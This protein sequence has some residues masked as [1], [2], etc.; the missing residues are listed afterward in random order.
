MKPMYDRVVVKEI[1]PET[2][3]IEVVEER[4]EQPILGEVIAISEEGSDV[5]IGDRILF[6]K[7]VGTHFKYNGQNLICLRE[8]DIMIRGV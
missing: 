6:S 7:Y 2:E 3:G 8:E 5:N 1:K 4:G